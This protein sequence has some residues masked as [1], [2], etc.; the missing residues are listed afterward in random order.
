MTKVKAMEPLFKM[1]AT[2]ENAH[3]SVTLLKF[4]LGVCKIKY[5]L[6]V[7]PVQCTKQLWLF[8]KFLEN[9]PRTIVGAGQGGRTRTHQK[10]GQEIAPGSTR[11]RIM[12]SSMKLPEA[13]TWTN[14]SPS[15]GYA[16]YIPQHHFK[17]WLQYY[18]RVLLFQPGTRCQRPQC[19]TVMDTY[20][21]HLLY[22]D[23]GPHR[24]RRH[25]AQVKLLAR[26]LAKAARHPRC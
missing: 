8:D 6:R 10:K 1:V 12:R 17:V 3:V 24:I 26:D 2:L 22:C 4:C 20:G 9:G 16:T 21:D 7:S 14:C 23:R 15:T 13:K 19:E 5:L 25:D 11:A 18:C